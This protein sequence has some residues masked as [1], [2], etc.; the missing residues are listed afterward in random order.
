[1]KKVVFVTGTRADFGKLK[2]LISSTE[3][4]G[5]F[6]VHIYVTGMHMNPKYGR[7]VDEVVKC[8]FKNIFTCYNH[9]DNDSMDII[10]SKTIEGFSQFVKDIKP[11]LIV[12]HG[13]RVEALGC[14]IVGALNNFLVAHIE[15]GEVSG[16]IDESIRH[17]VSKLAH[18]HLVCNN[19]A[20]IRL[21][22]MGEDVRSIF[23]VGSPDV[24]VILSDKLPPI[25]A[26]KA[27]YEIDFEEFAILINHPVTTEFEDVDRQISNLVSAVIDS[28]LNY[29]VIY[30]NNDSGS[31]FIFAEYKKLK[32]N[33]HF[34]IFPS[35]RFEYFLVLLANAKFIIGNSSAGIRE[36]PYYGI[37][38]VNIGTRQ[39]NRDASGVVLKCDY[40]RDQILHAIQQAVVAKP[41]V[42]RPFGVG[43]SAR[44]FTELLGG[45]QLWLIG[46]QK[47]FVDSKS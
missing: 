32:N 30:P 7:T 25:E 23:E 17:A 10:L 29:V 39:N 36:A 4:A 47:Q 28:K 12:I 43:D 19:E 41:E 40:Y 24:D 44:R 31:D 18:A 6:E 16:T 46:K 34:R 38:A 2:P 26:V 15:G 9:N 14:A 8:G 35:L 11:D 21:T 1:M 5:Q 42:I 22:Q 37:P 20:K 45:E 33:S 27:Y 13:D 3:Q